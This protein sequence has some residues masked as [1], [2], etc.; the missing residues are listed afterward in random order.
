MREKGMLNK[1]IAKYFKVNPATI[2]KILNG[3][4]NASKL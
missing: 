1:D 3:S 2:S 4:R